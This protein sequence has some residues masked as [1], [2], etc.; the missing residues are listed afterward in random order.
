LTA[1]SIAG[2][3]N[4]FPSQVINDSADKGQPLLVFTEEQRARLQKRRAERA[5]PLNA[6]ESSSSV[7]HAS[8]REHAL[9]NER[10][11]KELQDLQDGKVSE[12]Q[13]KEWKAMRLKAAQ[14]ENAKC[15]IKEPPP[16]GPRSIRVASL[17][18]LPL[19]FTAEKSVMDMHYC[20]QNLPEL[21]TLAGKNKLSKF[22]DFWAP[23]HK[24][25][26]PMKAAFTPDNLMT[27]RVPLLARFYDSGLTT[28]DGRLAQPALFSHLA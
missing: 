6:V 3:D 2:W 4:L 16:R 18:D 11:Q 8:A 15:L 17:D 10:K 14:E 7:E 22:S 20:V 27:D 5:E 21:R 25:T 1:R 9:S 12:E 24:N 13:R 19:S 28:A 26:T 23:D